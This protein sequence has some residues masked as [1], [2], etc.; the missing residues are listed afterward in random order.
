MDPVLLTL[1]HF[2]ECAT[3]R[4]IGSLSIQFCFRF[5]KIIINP[6][7]FIRMSTHKGYFKN[8]DYSS[9]SLFHKIKTIQRSY[10]LF[11]EE[12]KCPLLK[13]PLNPLNVF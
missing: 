12:E 13:L 2:L 6:L 8:I 4:S 9:P 7:S 10:Q 1:K 3:I 11:S 5:V